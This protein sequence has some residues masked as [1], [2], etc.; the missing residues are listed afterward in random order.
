MSTQKLFPGE[1]A[2]REMAAG[3]GW[4][5]SVGNGWTA[6]FVSP[7]DDSVTL[8]AYASFFEAGVRPAFLL[9][10][11][12]DG[13]PARAPLGLQVWVSTGSCQVP[14]PE[15]AGVLLELP[16][17]P[18]VGLSGLF[19]EVESMKEDCRTDCGLHVYR[20]VCSHAWITDLTKL[21]ASYKV[22]EFFGALYFSLAWRASS[23]NSARLCAVP[24]KR[25]RSSSSAQPLFTTAWVPP[26]ASVTTSQAL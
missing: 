15:E 8:R 16:C 25:R 6:V 7:D 24:V 4:S 2:L 11:T 19:A 22:I 1:S 10:E 13:D 26:A 3:A 14:T 20:R 12:L 17:T 21:C 5:P 18:G 9:V 23:P